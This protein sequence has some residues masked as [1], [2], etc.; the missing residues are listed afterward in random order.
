MGNA[1]PSRRRGNYGFD[2]DFR[3]VPAKWQA[4]GIVTMFAVLLGFVA[5][6][7]VTGRA[8]AAVAGGLIVALLAFTAASFAFTTRAGKFQVWAR[9][10]DDLD[11]RGDEH[12]LD[13]GCGRGAVLLAAAELLPDGRAVGVDM[14]RPD[15]TGNSP[16]A[17]RRNA[18][19]EGV[20]ARV[21]LHTGD[22]TGLPFADDTFDVVV[23]S[24]VLHHVPT[25]AGRRAALDEAL[26]VLRPGGRLVLADLGHTGKYAA[27]LRT[28]GVAAERRN[29]GWR[30]WWGG[31]WFPSHLVTGTKS[32]DS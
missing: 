16:E 32:R 31:P 24:F 13:L 15:Q 12:L 30:V 3:L 5:Y 28:R 7:V 10:L 17:T 19:L 11:L 29:L 6:D 14:W 22:I 2:G 23:S 4:A 21:S 26:R 18:E 25:A 1:E 27:H 20:G 9:I 8:G